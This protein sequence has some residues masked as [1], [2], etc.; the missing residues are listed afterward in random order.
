MMTY[1]VIKTKRCDNTK[2]AYDNWNNGAL[3]SCQ[4]TRNKLNEAY[5]TAEEYNTTCSSCGCEVEVQ[6]KKDS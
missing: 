1:Y 5:S 3:N 2:H 6:I 4:A